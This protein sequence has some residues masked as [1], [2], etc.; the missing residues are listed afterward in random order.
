ML[1]TKDE[2]YGNDRVLN[3]HE[4]EDVA[5]HPIYTFDMLAAHLDSV[6]VTSRLIAYQI[7]ERCDGSGYPRRR[8][9]ATIHPLARI[10]AVADVFVALISPRAYRPA[11][12][13]YYAMEY[14]LRG[15]AQGVF[16]LA[17]V[18]GLLTAVSLFPLGSHVMLSDGRVGKVLRSNRA[19]YNRPILYVPGAV[20]QAVSSEIIDLNQPDCELHVVRAVPAPEAA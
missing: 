2:I 10:A 1:R 19:A 13:P 14:L 4:F 12:M 9:V 20:G 17:V 11:L 18:R 6:P 3:S 5:S 7:H 15:A 16:D 8:Q